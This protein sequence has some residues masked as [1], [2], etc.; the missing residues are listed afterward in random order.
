ME[1][2]YFVIHRTVCRSCRGSGFVQNSVWHEFYRPFWFGGVKPVDYDARAREMG[3]ADCEAMPPEEVECGEC[4]GTG[5]MRYEVPLV[6]AL[7]KLGVDFP[8]GEAVGA[9][10]FGVNDLDRAERDRQI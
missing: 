7:A 2:V 10:G 8:G 5:E 3:Y 4:Q 1:P 6:E 9:E